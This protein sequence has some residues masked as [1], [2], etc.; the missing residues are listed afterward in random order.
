M[1]LGG[2]GR[3]AWLQ[4]ARGSSWGYSC[5]LGLSL[6]TLWLYKNVA[7]A[8]QGFRVLRGK[9]VTFFPLFLFLVEP[10]I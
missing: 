8:E 2:E 3:E 1:S 7:K 10:I 6:W 4:R 5:T 9:I